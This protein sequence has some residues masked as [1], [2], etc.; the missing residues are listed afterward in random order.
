[1]TLS[2]GSLLWLSIP[3]LSLAWFMGHDPGTAQDITF[4]YTH[5]DMLAGVVGMVPMLIRIQVVSG[6]Q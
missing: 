5:T 1:M 6:K 3:E 2:D 4:V